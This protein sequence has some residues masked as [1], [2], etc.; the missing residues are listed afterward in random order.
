V[1]P[2]PREESNPDQITEESG[3]EL[4]LLQHDGVVA[5]PKATEHASLPRLRAD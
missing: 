2:A 4:T 3:P 1:L 5:E